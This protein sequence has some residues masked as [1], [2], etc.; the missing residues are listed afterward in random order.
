MGR[1]QKDND[2]HKVERLDLS[3]TDSSKVVNKPR[4]SVTSWDRVETE[5]TW[6][7]R[8]LKWVR[9]LYR[10]TNLQQGNFKVNR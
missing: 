9:G 2:Q 5:E 8:P 3:G 4:L 6:S 7:D 10:T 1:D